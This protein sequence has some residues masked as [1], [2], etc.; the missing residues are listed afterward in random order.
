[1]TYQSHKFWGKKLK[2]SQQILPNTISEKDVSSL[3]RGLFSF[4]VIFSSPSVKR[5]N[6]MLPAV[7]DRIW[8]AYHTCSMITD[9]FHKLYTYHPPPA[10]P[11]AYLLYCHR[12]VSISNTNTTATTLLPPPQEITALY[13]VGKRLTFGLAG[14]F[15]L[16]SLGV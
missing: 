13:V 8:F 6:T 1:M 12:Y 5:A 2:C 15:V 7:R 4:S 11:A 3:L 10:P 9:K 14:H 16:S